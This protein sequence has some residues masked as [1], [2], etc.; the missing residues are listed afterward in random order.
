MPGA[1]TGTPATT[2]VQVRVE[3]RL[4]MAHRIAWKIIYGED[5]PTL[6]DHKNGD[7]LDNRIDNLRLAT[8]AQNQRNR[9][10]NKNNKSGYKGVSFMKSA[11]MWRAELGGKKH[12]NRYLG[13]FP[14][15]EAA[16]DAYCKAA[17]AEWGEFFNPG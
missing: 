11:G 1:I 4:W 3:G 12:K 6:I 16:H 2:G 14:T 5:A 8:T 7:F 13:C 15:P 9:R 10:K 17:R